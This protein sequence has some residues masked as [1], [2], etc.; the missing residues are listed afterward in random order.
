MLNKL[1]NKNVFWLTF[2]GMLILVV[3]MFIT[4]F[5]LMTPKKIFAF[6]GAE[7][8][9]AYA[10]GGRG[11][12]VYHVRTVEDSMEK[13]TL[14]YALSQKGPRTIV[15]DVSG[16]ISLKSPLEITEGDLTIAGQTAP[17]D[18]IC[19]KDQPVII[20]ADNVIVR[21][22]R[23][24]PGDKV[25]SNAL[26]IHNRQNI[27]ID[28]CSM[29]W[30]AKD[31]ISI[32]N[33][34]NLTMQWCIISEALTNNKFGYRGYGAELGG[35]DSSFHHNLFVHNSSHNPLFV[36]SQS[37]SVTVLDNVDFRNN[38]MFNWGTNSSQ[39]IKGA[40][41]NLVNNYYKF[42]PASQISVRSQIVETA[43]NIFIPKG[44]RKGNFLF[45]AGNF[46]YMN[47]LQ[48]NDNRMGVYPNMEYI[49]TSKNNLISPWEFP[50]EPISMSS[51]EGVLERVLNYAG[52]SKNRDKIDD[53]VTQD[54][55]T[56]SFIAKGS[57][58]SSK[59]LIDS[60]EDVGGYPLYIA[61]PP[62]VDSDKDGIPDEWEFKHNLDPFNPDDGNDMNK[63][64]KG[65]TNLEV[66]L[67]GIVSD[68]T[69][70]QN[71]L[72]WPSKDF[73]WLNIQKLANLIK[74]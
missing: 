48:T 34:A 3:V 27:I 49:K 28:H 20:N 22:I 57:R 51:S 71:G 56:S 66:Y 5:M 6:P 29:S 74:R 32:S 30:A 38:V 13:G 9:G 64:H 72:P 21:Y 16:A 10:T 59:G 39:G 1:F 24:R 69:R 11:G 52:A 7:G 15:F 17:G 42:G 46:V 44:G 73:F 50:H 18:G 53:R 68:I 31:N 12:I 4:F 61:D 41:Y 67:N 60:Q 45:V 62:L 25:D 40:Q 43:S 23:F 63:I 14:R 35:F 36:H 33:N 55:R 8:Y 54:V 47:P 58:G 2:G 70:K 65:Y 26:S 19:L 37:K